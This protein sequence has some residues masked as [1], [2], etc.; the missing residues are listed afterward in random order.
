MYAIKEAV[1]A[2]EH[3]KD[4]LDTAI[5]YMDIRAY[6]KD[7]ERYY[8]RAEQETGVRFI[9]SRVHSI[10]PDAPG[11]DDLRIEYV[12][13]TGKM[14]VEIFDLVVLSTGLE[15]SKESKALAEKIGIEIDTSGFAGTSSFSPIA[16]SRPGVFTCGVFCGPKDIPSLSN[17]GIGSICGIG[18]SSLRIAKYSDAG[19]DLSA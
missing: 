1:I 5:F 16:S 19:K 7:F 17:G 11:S 9:R 12:D 10:S 6:G 8:N 4:G 14:H 13:E 3:A 2:K 18:C 15:V